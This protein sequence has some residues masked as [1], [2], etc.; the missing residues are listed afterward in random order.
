MSAADGRS[1][2][3]ASASPLGAL[4]A[5][6]SGRSFQMAFETIVRMDCT[7]SYSRGRSCS[8]RAPGGREVK[9]A[10]NRH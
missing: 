6:V 10:L 9:K 7:G 1:P 8:R 2:V 3:E 5:L 4:I